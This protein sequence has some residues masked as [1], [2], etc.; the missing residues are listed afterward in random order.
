M[1]GLSFFGMALSVPIIALLGPTL[2]KLITPVQTTPLRVEISSGHKYQFPRQPQEISGFNYHLS[3]AGREVLSFKGRH[4]RLQN[5]KIGFLRFALLQEIHVD[6]GAL[7]IRQ[8]A[9]TMESGPN[10]PQRLSDLL[11]G[12]SLFS[13][14]PGAHVSALV[15]QPM[16]VTIVRERRG[17]QARITAETAR[18]QPDKQI[19]HFEGK[20][21][22]SSGDRVLTT[23][24]LDVDQRDSS[25]TTRSYSLSTPQ[26]KH[27][28][29]RLR[30]DIFLTTIE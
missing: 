15:C 4:L 10:Q 21:A 12:D 18:L 2:G 24:W 17:Q 7:F 30:S 13:P 3:Q 16:S 22:L 26:R 1:R 11:A 23:E 8:H 20:V 25:I 29:Q 14:F 6:H 5:K 19:I 28:G 27:H 9:G